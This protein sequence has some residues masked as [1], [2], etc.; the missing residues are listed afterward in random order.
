MKVKDVMTTEII[1]VD[2]DEDLAHV[3]TLMKKHD[4]TKIPVFQGCVIPSEI[5]A[6][7]ELSCLL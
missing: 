5:F 6:A 2:K 4:I 3:L 7:G 1:S